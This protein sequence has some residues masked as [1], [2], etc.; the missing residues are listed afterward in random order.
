MNGIATRVPRP[1]TA[2]GLTAD[3]AGTGRSAASNLL[4]RR[5]PVELSHVFGAVFGFIGFV[6]GSGRLRDN[7]LFTHI[8]TGRLLNNGQ[9]GELWN[10]L[11]DPYLYTSGGRSWV[12][13][14]WLAS[15]LFAG[16]ESG[17]GG[18]GIRLVFAVT[19]ALLVLCVWQLSSV[20]E[21]VT[22]RAAVC[23]LV[24][25]VGSTAWSLRP[26]LFGLLFLAIVLLALDGRMKPAWMIPVMWLWV[27]THGSFPIAALVVGAAYAGARFD[28]QRGD[29]ERR[30]L[31]AVVTGTIIGGI[32]NPVGPKLLLFPIELLGRG[33]ILQY[34]I[35][36][37]SPRFNENWIRVFL[38]ALLLSIVALMR[39]PSYRTALPV[40]VVVALSLIAMR[41][42]A[43]AVVVLT[44]CLSR[45]FD[46]LGTID[47]RRPA[48]V[49][50]VI[51][52]VLGVGAAAIML[53]SSTTSA[54]NLESYP[55][56]ALSWI[57]SRSLLTAD[58]NIT[59]E[60][61]VGNYMEWRYG[62][63]VR[64]Y[65]DDR[66]ELHSDELM[67]QYFDLSTAKAG[68]VETVK[69][70]DVVLWRRNTPAE[71]VLRMSSDWAVR[72]EDEDWFIAC[73]PTDI[74]CA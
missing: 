15:V 5:A 49:L 57:E 73:R 40:L 52:V 29:S 26:L 48:G 61:F 22:V 44:P 1:E 42:I 50:R 47:G 65:M 68:W 71:T 64:V 66:F 74:R 31:V 24:C 38:L 10:G 67:T 18:N 20:A 19:T 3:T 55:Q 70:A 6:I 17:L 14:S 21:S 46:G 58:A 13:Q 56:D 43:V 7:S 30:V 34:V 25:L 11:P 35:E 59:H 54:Y 16:A 12:V 37:R 72:Y 62:T 33:D 39:R 23:V 60:D 51:P 28:G 9:L 63:D 36:W 69:D 4:W 45:G 8:A 53:V 2:D 32:A 41:N 27:N